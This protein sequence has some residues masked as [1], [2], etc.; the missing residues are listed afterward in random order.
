MCLL[1]LSAKLVKQQ[2]GKIS[3]DMR[4]GIAACCGINWH[5]VHAS[6]LVGEVGE[7]AQC[8]FACPEIYIYFYVHRVV[9]DWRKSG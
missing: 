3:R 8:P 2:N 5:H 4:L 9:I 6:L 7:V 1:V